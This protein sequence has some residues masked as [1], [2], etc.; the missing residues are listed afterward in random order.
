MSSSQNGNRKRSAAATLDLDEKPCCSSSLTRNAT[1][2]PSKRRRFTIDE[3][4]ASPFKQDESDAMEV[5]HDDDDDVMELE[6]DE[7]EEMDIH[8]YVREIGNDKHINNKFKNGVFETTFSIES[9]PPNPEHLLYSIFQ[10]CVNAAIVALYDRLGM[11]PDELGA[12]V[13]SELLDSPVWTP[14]R[15][16]HEDTADNILNRFLLVIQSRDR[17]GKGNVLG[18]PF[19]VRIDAVCKKALPTVREIRGSGGPGG[20]IGGIDQ[21]HLDPVKHNVS[22]W[23]VIANQIRLYKL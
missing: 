5:V 17:E 16:I 1:P 21:S 3:L 12:N 9:L 23:R 7:D 13:F 8:R 18:A 20:Y 4:L 15:P 6:Q 2:P 19:T 11:M 22:L 10:K 14:L